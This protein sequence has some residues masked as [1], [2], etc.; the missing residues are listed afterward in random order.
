[1]G[2]FT[3]AAKVARD[4]AQANVDGDAD[5]GHC[6][7][8]KCHAV[9]DAAVNDSQVDPAFFRV[10]NNTVVDGDVLESSIGFSAEL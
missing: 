3:F 8:G 9:D 7:V 5:V 10:M 2:G 4:I 1:M 6:D